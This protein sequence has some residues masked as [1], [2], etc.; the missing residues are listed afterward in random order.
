MSVITSW[1]IVKEKRIATAFNVEG[2]KKAGG[3]WNSMGTPIVYTSESLALATLE[4]KVHL[5][6]YKLLKAYKCLSIQ[7]DAKYAV[8]LSLSPSGWNTDP[9]GSASMLVG[10]QWIDDG[11]SAVLE[12]PSV[13]IPG[14][15]NY[16]INPNHTDFL[17]MVIGPPVDYPYDSRIEEK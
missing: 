2:A 4:I 1:R 7:F 11:I 5:P 16:L 15:R 14:E 12:V 17:K 13:I 8:K 3:R 6:S 10:D 9:P